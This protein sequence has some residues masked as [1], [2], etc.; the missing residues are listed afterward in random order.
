MLAQRSAGRAAAH[1]VLLGNRRMLR[2]DQ[3][4]AHEQQAPRIAAGLDLTHFQVV[5]VAVDFG[6]VGGAGQDRLPVLG[7]GDAQL[8]EDAGGVGLG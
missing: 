8:V 4:Q 7:V 1:S 3:A 5:V 6:D 2:C